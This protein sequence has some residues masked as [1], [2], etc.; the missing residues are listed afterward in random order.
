MLKKIGLGIA[1]IL[2][3]LLL[4]DLIVFKPLINFDPTKIPH[5]LITSS[6]IDFDRVY[7]ISQ[8]R[9]GA[10][11]DY[12]NGS[13]NGETCRSMK[14]YFNMTHSSVN[15]RPV[16]SLPTENDPNIRIYAP[17]D[18]R[19]TV[20]D[21]E[22]IGTQ[23]HISSDKYPS[24]RVRI[25]HMDLLDG[26]KVGSKVTAGEQIGIIGPKDGTDFSV[27]AT[28]ITLGAVYLS[29]FETMTD[30][31]F[32]PYSKMGFKREDFVISK[33]YRDAQ[34]F[35]CGGVQTNS[36]NKEKETF[37]HSKNRDSTQ[38]FVFF[39]ADPYPMPD[40]QYRQVR[41]GPPQR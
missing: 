26:Y 4:I 16:R 25:F 29:Y 21:P 19:I 9:S 17:F 10:G 8:F 34:P 15:N 7:A 12:S 11:H 27:E 37:Q 23:V 6:F 2:I 24:Y 41:I 31:V 35:L 28:T 32:E 5:D 36:L 22:H 13:W 30:Q 38:D 18:G 14:H 20:A 3:T 33:E 1:L 40:G 39:K